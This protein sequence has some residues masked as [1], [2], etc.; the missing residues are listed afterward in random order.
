MKQM[1]VLLMLAACQ[2]L[3][4]EGFKTTGDGKTYSLQL[5]STMEGTG[6][7]MT[8][9]DSKVC[10]TLSNDVTIAE[11]DKFV[12]D[13]GVT[14]LFDD[15]V[16]L[17]VE[18]EADFELEEGSTFD[19]ASHSDE[20]SPVGVRIGNEESQ[21]TVENC[22]FRYVGL[23]CT[24]SKGLQVSKCAFYDNNTAI[25]QAALTLGGSTA[26]FT[27]SDCTFANNKK[28]AIAGAANFYNPLVIRHCTFTGNGQANGNTP[29][30]NL[31]AA[32]SVVVDGCT[33]EGDT[34]LTMVGG[35]G[36]SNFSAVEGTKVVVRNCSISDC[37]YGI[38][39]VGPVNI[40]ITGNNM[41][42]NHYETNPM[43]GGS[44]ISLY[45]PYRKTQA[46]VEG[47]YIEGSYWGVT[48]IGCAYVNLGNMDKS[49][50]YNPGGNVFKDN[51]FDG[52]PYDLYNNS[53]ITVYAQ[54]NT[55]S[56]SEQTEEQIETVI[57]HQHDD[58]SLGQV[59][60]MPAATTTAIDSSLREAEGMTTGTVYNIQGQRMKAGQRGIYIVN[61]KK[62]V[63]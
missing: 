30:L 2:Q 43:N 23:R 25:G 11:G 34:Q 24:S 49:A 37:R 31:T 13:D 57:Y 41:L 47:N 26:P 45:D 6:V 29:Q 28:A 14:V 22:T 60:F 15:G 21:T 48:V 20:T 59:I 4:A 27:I 52:Q 62:M 55:W 44:G 61:G 63:R 7:E 50:N 33:I 18:G 39:T 1:I 42:N 58:A 51:G 46:Y 36:I 53:T 38:G 8:S 5:L 56:V 10:Y 3:S 16:T 9:D 12:M 19:S 40:S 54:N 17:T 32:D 35:I